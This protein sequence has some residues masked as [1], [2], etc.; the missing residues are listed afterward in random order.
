V[1]LLYLYIHWDAQ[2]IAVEVAPKAS[3][4]QHGVCL[5]FRSSMF[6]YATDKGHSNAHRHSLAQERMVTVTQIGSEQTQRCTEAMYEP[7]AS[8]AG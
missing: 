3:F 1:R 6:L 2:L 7:M 4:R 8:D 5:P